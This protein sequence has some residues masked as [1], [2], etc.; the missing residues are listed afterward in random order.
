MQISGV[1][2]KHCNSRDIP[3]Q[4]QRTSA[5]ESCLTLP[6]SGQK[7][8]LQT[9]SDGQLCACMREHNQQVAVVLIR[10]SHCKKK[11]HSCGLTKQAV[12]SAFALSALGLILV[13]KERNGQIPLNY[14]V[15]LLSSVCFIVR[16][17]AQ[18]NSDMKKMV[19][20]ANMLKYSSL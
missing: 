16:S 20:L 17:F 8:R 5:E 13:D 11:S 12:L 7:N 1:A 15:G 6:A 4:C 14:I 19:A 3:N 18:L 2:T 9:T 10:H